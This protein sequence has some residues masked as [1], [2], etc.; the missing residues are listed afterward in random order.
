MGVVKPHVWAL[1]FLRLGFLFSTFG[2][3]KALRLGVI[4]PYVLGLSS[5][6][7]GG[8]K[9]LRSGVVFLTFGG[10]ISYS[11]VLRLDQRNC[12]AHF[13]LEGKHLFDLCET[14]QTVYYRCP[15]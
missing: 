8:C 11:S 5:L 1:F 2:D 15:Y 9:S 7:F 10:C 6:T 14:W 13:Y 3:C 12:Y 4:K